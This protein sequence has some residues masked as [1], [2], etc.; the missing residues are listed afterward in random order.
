MPFVT[1]AIFENLP[2][3]RE[4]L[5]VSAFPKVVEEFNDFEASLGVEALK[6]FITKIRN[7]RSEVNV[8]PSKPIAIFV[9]TKEKQLET[10][11]LENENYLQRF[12][13]PEKLVISTEIEK[14][15]SAMSLVMDGAEIYLPLQNLLNIE[16]EKLRLTKELGKWKKEV[17]MVEKKLSNERFVQNAK[18]EVVEKE[19]EKRESHLQKFQ[20]VEKQLAELERLT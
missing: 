12:T 8:A 3:K 17:E 4:S 7:A 20:A 1:E 14:P 19:R 10:F 6:E 9:Q 18:A 5:V 2:T 16:A 15:E 13:N 11:F